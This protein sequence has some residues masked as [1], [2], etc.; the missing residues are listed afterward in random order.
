MSKPTPVPDAKARDLIS[1]QLDR[2]FLVEAGAGSGKTQK[3]AERMAA[4]V[5]TGAYEIEQIAAVTFTRKAAAELRGRFQVAL[6][7]ER[8]RDASRDRAA[9]IDRALGNLERFFAGTIHAFCAR[10]LRERPVE[11]GVSPGFTELN[12]VEEALIRQRS[13]RD[14]RS[15]ALAA[16]ESNLMELL[17]A[18]ITAKQLDK[19][20]ETVCLYEDVTF[21]ADDAPKPD[22]T[23]ACAAIETFWSELQALM[24]TQIDPDS[25]CTTQE[26]AVRF[27]RQWRGYRRGR[28][29]APYVASLMR[30]WESK[31][32]VV[33]RCWPGANGKKAQQLHADFRD[34]TVI[35]F[36]T[37]W[38]Q[39]LYARCVALLVQARDAARTERRRRNTVSFNDLLMLTAQVLRTNADVRHALQKKYRWLLVDEFQDTDPIQAEIMFLLAAD[40]EGGQASSRRGALFVVGDPKQSIYRFRRAD[41]E[42]YN[43]VRA[44]LAGADGSGVLQ[45]TT[46]FRSVPGLCDWANEVFE[47]TFPSEPSPQA[48]R[49]APLQAHRQPR[50]NQPDIVKLDLAGVDTKDDAL[51]KEEA[52]RIARYIRAEV[53]AKRRTFGDFMILTR[54]KKSLRPYATALEGLE[55]PIEV[56]GAGAFDESDEVRELAQLLQ[57]LADPQDAVALVGVL[58]GSL[59]GL[60]DRDLFAFRQ[61]GGYFSLF[62]SE[63][64]NPG[65]SEP[66]P[67]NPGT[68][69]PEPQNPRTSEP[70]NLVF[71]ALE[72]LRLW[73]HWTKSLPAG[74][75]LER[76]V[77]DSGY[78]ALAATSRGGVEAGDLLHAVDRVRAVVEGGFTLAEAADAL[79]SWCGLDEDGPEESNEVDSLPLEP[80]RRDVV[81]LMNIHKAKGLEADVVFL[82]DP[83][84]GYAPRVD[85]RIVREGAE[86]RGYFQ[87]Q[88][89]EGYA[90]KPIAEPPGWAAH[91]QAELAFVEAE[92]ERLMY[93]AATRAKDMLV[94]GAWAGSKGNRTIAWPRLMAAIGDAPALVVPEAV[95]LPTPTPIDL[96][97][98]VVAS[99]RAARDAAHATVQR[100]SWA[101]VSVTAEVKRL[102]RVAFEA[103]D[104]DG[105]DADDA[106]RTIVPDTASHRAD[107]GVAW[108]TLVHGLLEHAVRHPATTDDDLRRLALWLT[109]EEPHLRGV[110]D[111]AIET[112]R[113]VVSSDAL[114]DA[115]AATESQTEVPF[116]VRELRDGVPTVITGAIDLVHRTDD[117]WRVVDYKTDADVAGAA[118]SPAYAAQV[119]AYADAWGAVTG[120]K[121]ETRVVSAR[122]RP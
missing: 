100:P 42:I 63:P 4:G 71:V 98:P 122:V 69:E 47:T 7:A 39:Y 65:T 85:V 30:I 28:R 83:L 77:D 11:A 70:R 53:D 27:E 34:T 41:I 89:G 86:P 9:R 121:V 2:S 6:E 57:A 111:R 107:A 59:F 5:A 21:P 96:G 22:T 64:Q 32:S 15:Q 35:P 99:A 116:A 72:S 76:I 101:A 50:A 112:V 67:Q 114:A 102:P 104:E 45:L 110:I 19:A 24:P 91:Q 109:M 106:T 81:R 95:T 20:L 48:P 74:A 54:R 43:E 10:L 82:V 113:T 52:A 29:D 12:D 3:L 88:E 40:E 1:T 36:L 117:G 75:A 37:A 119:Q 60:S 118:A 44:R 93:V 92:V 51:R 38:R 13:W 55:I 56:T 25:T 68:S 23:K 105:G 49:F 80:G 94:I 14:Y 18:G 97:A 79:A 66:E 16:G 73:H 120:E 78:L 33:Q 61:A 58:R 46:N 26:R 103:G 62:S 8:T 115:R 90:R 84:G 108:G 31:P 87:I 17:E